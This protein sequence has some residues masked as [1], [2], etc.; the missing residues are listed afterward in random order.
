M[1][2]YTG[3]TIMI[4]LYTAAQLHL[5]AIFLLGLIISVIAFLYKKQCFWL[6]PEK[7]LKL[8]LIEPLLCGQLQWNR[9]QATAESQRHQRF[10]VRDEK[11]MCKAM[12]VH[13]IKCYHKRW[14][15]ISTFM[16]SK[17]WCSRAANSLTKTKRKLGTLTSLEGL[18][19]Y[20]WKMCMPVSL[21]FLFRALS[22]S[23]T[24][25]SRD[26][27]ES[28]TGKLLSVFSSSATTIVTWL[29]SL[30]MFFWAALKRL[31]RVSYGTCRHHKCSISD[32]HSRG[33]M[34]LS[35]IL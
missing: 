23:T 34:H 19:C 18:D 17:T 30:S 31:F 29:V 3:M 8:K 22:F 13:K 32:I 24:P 15:K 27:T 35:V 33:L 5:K 10:T 11:N 6:L 26:T 28:T 21:T 14:R 16:P 2:T 25:S 20:T 12:H 1:T 7:R 9:K 4:E